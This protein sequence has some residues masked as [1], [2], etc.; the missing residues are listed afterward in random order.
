MSID[1]NFVLG[2][3]ILID[4]L[5]MKTYTLTLVSI[6]ETDR[7]IDYYY[8]DLLEVSSTSRNTG[9]VCKWGDTYW[10]SKRTVSKH[11]VLGSGNGT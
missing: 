5:S 9:N 11:V 10:E 1:F 7:S 3:N 6:A 2:Y 8:P 4:R